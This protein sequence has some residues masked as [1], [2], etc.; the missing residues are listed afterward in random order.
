M[1]IMKTQRYGKTVPKRTSIEVAVSAAAMACTSVLRGEK[2]RIKSIMTNIDP[3]A[4]FNSS[5]S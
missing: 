3:A 4:S 1:I 2:L 5:S